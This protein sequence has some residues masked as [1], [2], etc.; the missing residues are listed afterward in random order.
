MISIRLAA[1]GIGLSLLLSACGGGGGGG[2][3]PV[4][5]TPLTGVAIDG[6]LKNATAFLDLNDNGVLDTNEPQAKT[7]E[8]GQ[9]TLL[10][11]DTEIKNHRVV[12]QVTTDATDSI[13]G[14]VDKAFKLMAPAG[15]GRVVSPLTTLV[16]AHM[17]NN[18]TLQ[19]AASR[20]QTDLGLGQF[21]V[22]GNFMTGSGHAPAQK[23]A[24]SV[25]EVLKTITSRDGREQ[26]NDVRLSVDNKIKPIHTQILN[27]DVSQGWASLK[28]QAQVW[29]NPDISLSLNDKWAAFLL[30]SDS[31]A[32]KQATLN[33][34]AV[35]LDGQFFQM[36]RDNQAITLRISIQGL[37]LSRILTLD[38]TAKLV[39]TRSQYGAAIE[40][41]QFAGDLP[42]LPARIKAGEQGAYFQGTY[43]IAGTE[44]ARV[45]SEFKTTTG[46]SAQSLK[47]TLTLNQTDLGKSG[48]IDVNF[49]PTQETYEFTLTEEGLQLNAVAATFSLGTLRLT[50]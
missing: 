42:S 36:A 17:A 23:M 47:F 24:V 18:M 9:F 6:Y 49:R 35:G 26:L 16:A 29:A 27:F 38:Q 39:S 12:V 14:P 15:E 33:G 21:D 45:N 43:A 13:T 20:V 22:M 48:C 19:Q 7:G 10:A 34:R 4:A 2:D 40:S 1:T 37:S 8:Q 41:I 46:N 31:P 5:K 3:T 11:T 50:F 28:T 32:V 30:A 25:T 44:C